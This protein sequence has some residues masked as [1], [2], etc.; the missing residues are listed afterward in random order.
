MKLRCFFIAII[1]MLLRQQDLFSQTSTYHRYIV[2]FKDKQDSPFSISDPAAFLSHRAID[3]RNRYDIPITEN[4][5]PVN[6]A[7][8]QQVIDIGVKLLNKS[9]W[10]NSIS[11]ETDDSIL[12]AAVMA[13]P[14]VKSSY[15]I[16]VR[17]SN[18]K[19]NLKSA[20]ESSDLKLSSDNVLDYGKAV[21]QIEMLHGNKLHQQG[22]KGEGIIIA[23]LDIGFN[24]AF[25]L[26]V[27]DS[28]FQEGRV[29]G[30]WNFVDQ[31]DSVYYSGTHGTSVLSTISA[32]S[33][34]SM[35]GTA[36][37]ASI[38]LFVT[39]DGA[40]EYPIEEHNWAAAAER[41]DSVGADMI[42]SSLGY[43][44][45]QDASFNYTYAQMDGNT[46]MVTR[47]ADYAAAKGMIVCN[48]AGNEG[49]H[50]WYYI[51]APAD[52]DS[53]LTVG[54]VDSVG[55]HTSFSSHGPSSDGDIKPN[56]VAQGIRATVVEPYSGTILTS[57]GTSFSN[58]I[59]AGMTACLW[60]AH[61]DK[62]NMEII[63][64]IE[65]SASLYYDPND[66]MGYGIPNYEVADLILSDKAPDE[67]A[68]SGPLI[69]PNPFNDIFG[70][71]Y[72][73]AREQNLEIEVFNIYGEK[74]QSFETE[75]LAGYN[76]LPVTVLQNASNGLYFLRLNFDDHREVVRVIKVQP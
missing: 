69:Y 53:I 39:E 60:Q 18:S 40:S 73:T 47:A 32:N 1:I 31:N 61:P 24:N 12:L 6:P 57:N 7:Y 72:Y 58:P 68:L 56:V 46:T 16:A 20:T 30:Q 52:A 70:M 2:E 19:R 34:G 44:E 21:N 74:I 62:N 50:P 17:S 4:D 15:P 66:S 41:A 33:P 51:I 49:N 42:T 59:I 3:R 54:A 25:N 26:S 37:G 38:Y 45:F 75:F 63:H 55:L 9:K 22:Y 5:L 71:L 27:F 10:L 36:P 29:L 11:I 64:A 48:S 76:Y 28:L 8:V 13:L 43:F 14:F 67:L 35:V 65:K 23:V